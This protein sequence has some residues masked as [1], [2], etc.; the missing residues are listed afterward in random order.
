[1][2]LV[3][4]LRQNKFLHG[5]RAGFAKFAGLVTDALNLIL[6]FFVYFLGAGLTAVAARIFKKHFLELNLTDKS[7][8]SYWI[9]VKSWQTEK[10]EYFYRIF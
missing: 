7:K 6:L 1:M 3:N 4:F 2:G 10:E 8:T 9:D 5:F